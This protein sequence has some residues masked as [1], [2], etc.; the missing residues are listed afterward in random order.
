MYFSGIPHNEGTD[1]MIGGLFARPRSLS[2]SSLRS[3]ESLRIKG[4]WRGGREEGWAM[5]GE[6]IATNN[7]LTD[8]INSK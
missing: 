6:R 2:P 1:W 7:D 4:V 3:L 5:V 8:L